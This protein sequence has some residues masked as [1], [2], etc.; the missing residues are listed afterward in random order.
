MRPMPLLRTLCAIPALAGALALTAVV[1]AAQPP[2]TTPA[3]VR[4]DTAA[5][6]TLADGDAQRLNTWIDEYLAL[7]LRRED[8]RRDIRAVQTALRENLAERAVEPVNPLRSRRIREL[9]GRLHDMMRRQNEIDQELDAQRR[10][11]TRERTAALWLLNRRDPQDRRPLPFPRG[12]GPGLGPGPGRRPPPEPEAVNAA[13]EHLKMLLAPPP[14]TDDSATTGAALRRFV[15]RMLW[16]LDE[17]LN[18][19]ETELDL[20]DAMATDDDSA[21][22]LS[23]EFLDLLVEEDPPQPTAGP[24]GERRE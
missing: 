8:H 5:T 13:I 23:L 2:P 14:E 7:Y 15:G 22:G 19:V 4:Q 11:L 3:P 9:M 12:Q 21:I 24:P 20:L 10:R 17:R 6:P 1:A 18:A 16:D